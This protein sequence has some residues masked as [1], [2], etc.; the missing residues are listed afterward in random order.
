MKKIL[1]I[2]VFLLILTGCSEKKEEVKKEEPKE[3]IKEIEEVKEVYNDLNDTK[4]GLYILSGNKLNLIHEY[5]TTIA[6][7][8]DAGVFQ[9]YPSNE[10]A[11]ALNSGFGDSF[12]NTWTSLP[13]Y[14]ELK[15]GFNVSY[16]LEN[17]ESVS[18]NILDPKIIY[19]EF[20]DYLYDDYANRYS[21]WYSH[22]EENE[23]TEDTLFTSIKLYSADV[24][25]VSSKVKLTVFTY[26][27]LDDF[28]SN[29]EYRGNSKYTIEICDVNKTC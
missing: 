20:Y 23:Y 10:E 14:K 11:I 6:N 24:N 29:N 9:I 2:L 12:Y 19:K 26:D 5:K 3:E 17:G 13:N 16:T 18:Y 22:I 25:K 27:S 4:I 7:D 15:I 21:S 8:I 28:D 1:T